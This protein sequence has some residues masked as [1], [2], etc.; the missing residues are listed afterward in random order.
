MNIT[1]IPNDKLLWM[2]IIHLA[3]V[4]SALLLTIVDRLM[5]RA[6][7]GNEPNPQDRNSLHS[8]PPESA[9]ALRSA[10]N[11]SSNSARVS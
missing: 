9:S 8:P 1:A 6:T 11:A 5:G 3:F 7:P 4:V 2:T 10:A